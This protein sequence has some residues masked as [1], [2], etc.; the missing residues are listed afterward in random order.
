MF[1]QKGESG[2]VKRFLQDFVLFKDLTE[3]ELTKISEII[4]RESYKQG[5][6]IFWEQERGDAFYIILEGLV[7]VFRTTEE[8]KN[9]TLSLLGRK[10]FF[11]E[12]ALLEAEN[13]S[14]SVKTIQPT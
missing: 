2:V 9:K 12:M 7:K 6:M 11:G 10:E 4:Y 1:I 8:G 13:R 3:A 5:T 14:A